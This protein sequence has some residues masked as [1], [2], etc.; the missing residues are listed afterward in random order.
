MQ[1][2]SNP[3]DNPLAA[4]THRDPYPYYTGLVAEH[5]LDWN[6]ALG[7]WVA[8]SAEAVG[9]VLEHPAC[10]VRPVSE[11]VPPGL[12]GSAAGEIFGRLVRMNDGPRHQQWKPTV[13]AVLSTLTTEEVRSFARR[14]AAF[15][16]VESRARSP[17]NQ[18]QELMSRLPVLCVGSLLGL[19][20]E[21]LDA[22]ADRTR[23]LVC[24]FTPGSTP[25][26]IR[27]GSE[28]AAELVEILRAR[29]RSPD[30]GGLLSELV[31]GVPN[32]E[33]RE[34]VL[35]ANA[36]G[37]LTQGYEATAGLIGNAALYLA[38]D[39]EMRAVLAKAP[40]G[41]PDFVAE[42]ARFDPPVQNTR[43][44]LAEPA[45]ILGR[46]LRE[47]DTILVLLAA[48]NR[49]SALN[50]EPARFDLERGAR[51]S[52]SSGFGAHACPGEGL[53]ATLATSALERLLANDFD[54]E[55]A[56]R[57]VRYRPS[58]NTRVPAFG[59]ASS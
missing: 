16:L 10:R 1:S 22:L 29:A 2:L 4:V 33:D 30:G 17:E 58:L 40:A 3:P 36:V 13:A 57:Q 50:P 56:A 7:L 43:R 5:P 39:Q 23:E 41:L 42:V 54:V 32:S 27:R 25:D 37:L 8:A 28:T 46:N 34:L 15:L 45:R 51:R 26:E 14:W 12:V 11:P 9:A 59:D 47:S 18:L 24:C 6:A 55:A 38:R 21:S 31:R 53:S 52:F 48:A 49:D 20:E 19:P 44:F 35:V